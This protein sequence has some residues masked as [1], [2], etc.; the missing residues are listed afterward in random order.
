MFELDLKG[1]V[2]TSRHGSDWMKDFSEWLEARGESFNG[3]VY[4]FEKQSAGPTLRRNLLTGEW[5]S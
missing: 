2:V 4:E 3:G 1:L 5:K